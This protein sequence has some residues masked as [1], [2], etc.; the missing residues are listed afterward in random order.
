MPVY[1]SVSVKKGVMKDWLTMC[2]SEPASENAY[3][4]TYQLLRSRGHSDTL[5]IRCQA[6][7]RESKTCEHQIFRDPIDWHVGAPH[8]GLHA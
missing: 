4:R 2:D 3:N 8:L 5:R 7:G 6:V 1:R